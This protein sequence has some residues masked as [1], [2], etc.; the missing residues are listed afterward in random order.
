MKVPS[1]RV[2]LGT[3]SGIGTGLDLSVANTVVIFDP[4]WSPA[5]TQQAMG[6]ADRL[7]Q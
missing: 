2:L 3:P 7:G 6:R 1:C 4:D 5:S